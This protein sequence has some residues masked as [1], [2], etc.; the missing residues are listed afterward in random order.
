MQS[1]T[2]TF[3]SAAIAIGKLTI[4]ASLI[5]G[6]MTLTSSHTYAQLTLEWEDINF[7]PTDGGSSSSTEFFSQNKSPNISVSPNPVSNYARIQK[8]I[9]TDLIRLDVVDL[10]GN[11]R[12]TGN[13]E[14]SFLFIPQLEAGLYSFRFYTNQGV[15]SE[16]VSVI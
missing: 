3:N 6:M 16:L 14:G 8:E 1:R 2:I 15:S 11:I 12:F 13:F 5:L 9:G 7:A 10:Q 4:L